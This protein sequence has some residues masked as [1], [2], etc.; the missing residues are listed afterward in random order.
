M[1]AIIV[2]VLNVDDDRVLAPETVRVEVD[3]KEP[4]GGR[5]LNSGISKLK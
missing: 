1:A 4:T 2:F 3:V 5:R